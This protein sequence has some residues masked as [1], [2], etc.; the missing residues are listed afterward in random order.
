M[1]PNPFFQTSCFFSFPCFD[2]PDRISIAMM[3]TEGV[4]SQL[5]LGVSLARWCP[6]GQA[7]PW[8]RRK[9]FFFGSSGA[10]SIT[11][12]SSEPAHLP[13]S[14]RC[15]SGLIKSE[16]NLLLQSA[17]ASRDPSRSPRTSRLVSSTLRRKHAGP[18]ANQRVSMGRDM[19]VC[20]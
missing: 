7:L 5:C 19:C 8:G 10:K 11:Q 1:C 18:V 13:P 2:I 15:L 16:Q 6:A 20:M 3:V 9:T 14:G 4:C 12:I 17:L